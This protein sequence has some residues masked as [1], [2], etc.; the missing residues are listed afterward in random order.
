MRVDY[1][2][3]MKLKEESFCLVATSIKEK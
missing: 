1:C 3:E 2:N